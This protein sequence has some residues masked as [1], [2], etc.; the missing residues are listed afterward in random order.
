MTPLCRKSRRFHGC[1]RYSSAEVIV[2]HALVFKCPF[3]RVMKLLQAVK[4]VRFSLRG[5]LPLRRHWLPRG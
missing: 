3:F 1:K 5:Q 2:R 4:Q